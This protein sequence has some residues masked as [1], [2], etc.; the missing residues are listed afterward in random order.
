VIGYKVK[1]VREFW[2]A[3]KKA[4]NITTDEYYAGTF[5]DPKYVEYDDELVRLVGEGRK[6]ATAHLDLDFHINQIRRREVG[7]YWVVV[8]TTMNPRY[9]VRITDVDAR[10]FNLVEE[11]FASREGERDISLA[12]WA[13]LHQDYFVLQCEDWGET[14]SDDLI[15]VCEGFKLLATADAVRN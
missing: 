7:D 11:S 5:V 9:L 8:D 14:W 10:P 12:F 1:A 4:L 13:K 15:T 6:Q 2:E 3:Q